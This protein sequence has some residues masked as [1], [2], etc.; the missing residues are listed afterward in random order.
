MSRDI[1]N[2]LD[3][4]FQCFTTLVV[5]SFFLITRKN[6]PSFSLK[7]LPLVLLLQALTKVC[8]HLSY[9][10]PLIA[11]RQQKDLT[12]ALSSSGWTTPNLS[13]CPCRSGAL[14]LGSFLSPSSG[15]T[16]TGPCPSCAEGSTAGCRNPGE[17]SPEQRGRIPSL[18]LLAI[19][20]LM[21]PRTHLAFW[22]ASAHCQLMSSFLSISTPKP[23]SSGLLLISSSPSQYWFQGLPQPKCRTLHLALLNL[24]M[25]NNQSRIN[26]FATFFLCCGVLICLY[27]LCSNHWITLLYLIHKV[28]KVRGPYFQ[29]ILWP[30]S[31]ILADNKQ[32]VLV[33][34]VV[35]AAVLTI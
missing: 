7:P 31:L 34:T 35:K 5:Q 24:M 21:Q 28:N 15:L 22:A 12:G 30:N 29:E 26:L 32:V 10:P 1:F 2:S 18:H 4:P 13:A 20:L 27:Q 33:K 16:P 11:E 25:L 19:L 6:L 14:A 9:K 8:P 3:N 23:F 17:V